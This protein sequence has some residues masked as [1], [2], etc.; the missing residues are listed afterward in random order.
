MPSLRKFEVGLAS[1]G[2]T[3]KDLTR[4]P[5]MLINNDRNWRLILA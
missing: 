2:F 1:R 3:T 5:V 4:D